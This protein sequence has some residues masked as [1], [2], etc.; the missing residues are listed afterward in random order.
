MKCELSRLTMVECS[1]YGLGGEDGA[2]MID[3]VNLK[4]FSMNKTT[5]HASVGAGHRLGELD[6]KLHKAGKRAMAH[7]TC[8]SVGIGGHATIVSPSTRKATI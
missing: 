4:D 1:N 2:L 5:W 6:K 3:L 8:P 7:G